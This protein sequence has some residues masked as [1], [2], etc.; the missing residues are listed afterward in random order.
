MNHPFSYTSPVSCQSV[1]EPAASCVFQPLLTLWPW[2]CNTLTCTIHK[3]RAWAE[4][5]TAYVSTCAWTCMHQMPSLFTELPWRTRIDSEHN[6]VWH[7]VSEGDRNMTFI[8]FGLG[9]CG[10]DCGGGNVIINRYPSVSKEQK[11]TRCGWGPGPSTIQER[12][13][14]WSCRGGHDTAK[15][16]RIGTWCKWGGQQIEAGWEGRH[17]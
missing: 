9:A 12:G 11:K 15:V 8:L 14:Q 13:M 3:L 7:P 10:G 1:K 6:I 17:G 4:C 5:T 16:A 2:R